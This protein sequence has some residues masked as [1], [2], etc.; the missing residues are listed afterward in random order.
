MTL[1]E[2]FTITVGIP[3]H[4]EEANIGQLLQSIVLQKG[5]F[6]LEKI[7]VVC[8]GCTDSTESIVREFAKIY[9]IVQIVS[10]G[11]RIGKNERLN[12]L[13]QTNA[14]DMLITLDADIELDGNF[15]F[16]K[17]LEPFQNSQVAVVAGNARPLPGRTFVEKLVVAKD[18]WWYEARKSFKGGNN[19]YCKGCC[20]A[21]AKW[22][23]RD[24]RFLPD[25]VGDQDIIY[26]N[27]LNQKKHFVFAYEAH[28]YFREVSTWK[29]LLART[30]RFQQRSNL[31]QYKFDID[32]KAEYKI[33]TKEKMRGLWKI[34]R[35]DP[36]YGFG[37]F[38][39]NIFLKLC[40]IFLSKTEKNN[41][42]LW[43]V[44]TSTKK[45]YGDN[46][47]SQ[48]V[49]DWQDVSATNHLPTVTVGVP[50]YNE[51]ANIRPLLTAIL[52]QCEINFKLDAVIVVSDG[53]QDRT[54]DEVQSVRDARIRLI[55]NES[56]KGQSFAQNMIFAIAQSDSVV[57]LEADT[58]PRDPEYLSQLIEP[59]A[60]ERKVGFVQGNSRPLP[61]RTFLGRVLKAQIDI[62][63]AVSMKDQNIRE[64]ITSGR[65]GR[66]FTKSVY[67]NLRWPS[68]VPEDSYALLWCHSRGIDVVF[69]E[70]AVCNFRCSDTI[71]DFLKERSKV[72]K[73]KKVLENYFHSKDVQKILKRPAYLRWRMFYEFISRHPFYASMY[74]VL[75]IMFFFLRESKQ[76]N[77]FWETT[78]T[79][80]KL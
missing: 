23:T 15:V 14:S 30:R 61:A 45:L 76:F 67:T 71:S 70:S 34:A 38:I 37:S 80:K 43:E 11:K 69:Q 42:A 5:K 24:F 56:R 35:K 58:I 4:N 48:L 73:G 46:V 41:S 29:E 16:E 75:V 8:D 31:A 40:S 36:F 3:A 33:P 39:L 26:L 2:K 62:Y 20:F 7:I 21:F 72:R 64:W 50:A 66:A 28:V 10:D 49:A 18:A 52:N 13:Y 57:I 77:D 55:D 68:A 54:V 65:G 25:T 59:I 9:P 6:I 27:V 47:I 12:F 60:N 63:H 19:I 1:S 74:A 51:E 53:S 17:L 32:I 78:N 79:T 44:I 22:F